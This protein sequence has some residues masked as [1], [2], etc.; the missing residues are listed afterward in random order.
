MLQ[1]PVSL[2][3][4]KD[5][6]LAASALRFPGKLCVDAAGD[7]LFI[8]DSNNHRCWPLL[9]HQLAWEPTPAELCAVLPARMRVKRTHAPSAELAQVH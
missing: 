8:S 5:P 6:A 3:R 2:E 9:G 4:D 1:V 7:R